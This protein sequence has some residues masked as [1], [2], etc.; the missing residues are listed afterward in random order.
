[1]TSSEDWLVLFGFQSSGVV[2]T[3]WF[4]RPNSAVTQPRYASGDSSGAFDC[5]LAAGVEF[6]G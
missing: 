6:R 5:T 3:E 1:M 2:E 4:I